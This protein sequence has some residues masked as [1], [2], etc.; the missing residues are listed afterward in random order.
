MLLA[1]LALRLFWADFL[2]EVSM[3]D[4]L[5]RIAATGVFCAFAYALTNLGNLIPIRFAG[6]LSFDPKDVAIVI[7]GFSLGPFATVII[8]IVVSLFEMITISQTGIA[9]F[10]M[11]VISSVC[12]ALLPA[13]VYKHKRTFKSAIVSLCVS[14]AITILAML[15]W[16]FLITPIYM[17]VPREAVQDMLLPVFFPFNLLKCTMNTVLIAVFYKP[18]VTALRKIKL[19][20]PSSKKAE[21]GYEDEEK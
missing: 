10:I 3:K 15:L 20:A 21:D 13:I 1:F 8:S 18:I 9:G 11:N 14:S 12:F 5:K 16:N 4:K 7:A 17:K 19:I 2:F 6:F